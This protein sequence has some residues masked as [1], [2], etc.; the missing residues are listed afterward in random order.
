MK[1]QKRHTALTL[2]FPLGL[3]YN[4]RKPILPSL[5]KSKQAYF[6]PLSPQTGE[7]NVFFLPLQTLG[8]SPLHKRKKRNQLP[9]WFH[10]STTQTNLP[11]FPKPLAFLP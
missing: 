5:R 7:P 2:S 10:S 6:S 11:S 4:G 8:N 3:P 9:P 1:E